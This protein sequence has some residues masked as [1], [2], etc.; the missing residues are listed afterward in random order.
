MFD[1]MP[2]RG[3]LTPPRRRLAGRSM[4]CLLASWSTA[5]GERLGVALAWVRR[6]PRAGR[7]MRTVPRAAP[8]H[9]RAEKPISHLGW[10]MVMDES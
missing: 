4:K 10:I 2:L 1:E 6:G 3:V 7:H 5:A 9:G 8:V